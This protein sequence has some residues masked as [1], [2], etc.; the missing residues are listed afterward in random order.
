[1]NLRIIS[2]GGTF[3]KVYDMLQ[4]KLRFDESQ[5]PK[6]LATARA[7]IPC[8]ELMLV[9]SLEMSDE[10]RHELIQAC[11]QATED[12]LVVI[13]GTDTMV[14]TAEA[15]AGANIP[16]TI[17]LTGAMVPERVADSD[18]VFNLGY[19]IAAAQLAEPGIW[20]AMNGRLHR[21]DSVYKNRTKGIF[22]EK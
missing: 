15:L 13:H 14:E 9:D 12:Q 18:A 19:A 3:E 10:Q 16:K 17:V 2:T 7:E 6:L 22:E 20:V 8:S 1:M 4:G 21:W 5:I 11:R